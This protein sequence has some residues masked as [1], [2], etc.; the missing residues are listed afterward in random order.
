MYSYN[1]TSCVSYIV[2]FATYYGSDYVHYILLHL[3]YYSIICHT[4]ENA[5]FLSVMAFAHVFTVIC[6]FC[7]RTMEK[8]GLLI[9]AITLYTTYT[10]ARPNG[11]PRSAC[12]NF[13]PQHLPNQATGRVPYVVNISSIGAFYSGGEKYPSKSYFL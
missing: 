5:L 7:F 10:E 3:Q 2:I 13:I 9:T 12:M 1:F 8:I 4:T 11:A 6:I